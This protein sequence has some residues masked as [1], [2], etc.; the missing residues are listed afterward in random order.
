[1]ARTRRNGLADGKL[2]EGSFGNVKMREWHYNKEQIP[3][4]RTIGTGGGDNEDQPD[5]CQE[6]CHI[7]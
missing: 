1:M 7:F 5:G 3:Y 4:K 2:L 6:T